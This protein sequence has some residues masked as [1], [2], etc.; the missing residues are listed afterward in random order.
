MPTALHP[1]A[2]FDPIPPDL[3]LHALVE[4]TPH[5]QW[6]TRITAAQI[7]NIGPQEFEKLVFLRVIQQGKPLVIEKWNDRLPKSLF[8]ADWLEKQY[9]KKQ[10]NVRDIVAQTDIPMTTGHYLRS[11]KQL[12]NQWTPATFRDERRQRLYLKDIDCPPEWFDRLQKIIPPN[13]FYMN[14]NVDKKGGSKSGEDLDMFQEGYS[15]APAGDL[16]SSLPEQMRAQN[17]MCYIG[18]EGTYTPAHKEMCASLG[19]NIMVDASGDENGEKP[20]SS[21]WFMTETKDRQVVREYFLSMLGHD[22][23]IEKHFAQINAWKKA[24]FPVYIVE[25]R[26]GDF[27]LVPPLAPHQVWNRGTRTIKVAWNR[28]TVETLE[29]ALH[30]ALPKARLVCRD[31][32]YKNKAIIYYTLEKYAREMKEMEESADIGILGFG[33]DLVRNSTRMKQMAAD[34][35]SLFRLFTEILV[36]EMFATKEKDVEYIEFD[37]CITCSYCRAN[38]FN[39]FLTC[40]HCVRQL[41]NGDEDTYDVCMECYAMGRSCLC[42]SNLSWCEQW[43]WSELVDR[44]E[45]WRA[46]IIKNDG[47]VSLEH[48]PPPLELARRRSGKKSLA[49]ICQEQLR[50]RPWKDLSIIEKPAPPP[51]DETSEVEIGENGRPLKKHT[52]RKRKKGDVYACHVC[53]HKDYC[54][55]L[56]FCSNEGCTNAYCFGVLY[57]AFDQMPQDIL[58]ALRWECPKCQGICNCAAC[59]RAGNSNPYIPKNTTLGHDTR[60]IADDRSVESLVDFRV[61]NL[62]WLKSV[63]EEGRSVASKRI[64]RLQ[65][66]AESEKAREADLAHQV[67][68]LPDRELAET[69]EAAANGTGPQ[70]APN[71]NGVGGTAQGNL[72]EPGMPVADMSMGQGASDYPDPSILNHTVG[73]GYY[74]QDDSPDRILFDP[75]Q[76]PTKEALVVDEEPEM[77]SEYLKKQLRIAKRRTRNEDDDP[78]FAAPRSHWRK[79]PKIDHAEKAD[80]QHDVLDNMDPALF[81]GDQAML[82]APGDPDS[83]AEQGGATADASGQEAG[84]DAEHRPF[85]PN[86]PALRHARPKESYLEDQQEDEFNDVFVPRSQRPPEGITNYDPEVASKDPLDVAAAAIFSAAPAA[87]A[88]E[89]PQPEKK[90]PG[91]KP[92]RPKSIGSQATPKTPAPGSGGPKPRGRP[93]RSAQPSAPVADEDNDSADIDAQLAEQLNAFD[94]DGE[95]IAPASSSTPSIHPLLNQPK[96]RGRPP[97]ASLPETASAAPVSASPSS[98][99]SMADRMKL[100]GKKFKI[101]ARKSINE[102]SGSSGASPSVPL[103]TIEAPESTASPSVTTPAEESP[104]PTEAKPAPRTAIR[105]RGGFRGRGR[106]RGGGRPAGRSVSSKPVSTSESTS[107]EFDPTAAEEEVSSDENSPSPSRDA[108]VSESGS[109]SPEPEPPR[110]VSKVTAPKPATKAIPEP[111]VYRSPSPPPRPAGPTVVR[112]DSVEL[113]S[114]TES[115]SASEES[116]ASVASDSDSDDEDIPA[117]KGQFSGTK[118]ATRGGGVRGRG[119][120]GRGRGRPRLNA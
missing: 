35:K 98:F 111:E 27:I 65:Q 57:R 28:T 88:Q 7:R 118:L 53:G 100:K 17:L 54:Y 107:D 21:I 29:M 23:E 22:I 24:T 61:H 108:S 44:Y 94:D 18:H 92:G 120:G 15:A 99:M 4:R 19:Q 31:E 104:A 47:F 43:R 38:I 78:D 14:E 109:F 30:E 62:T 75:Y 9:N 8:S 97:R 11:M 89:A 26:V 95:F 106:G 69:L 112:L 102:P 55:R 96:R 74:E 46:L 45:E 10:E 3:D 66:A 80:A 105:G 73:R 85:S 2:K 34:F 71:Q 70:D 49:Q 56:A 6:V 60:P 110:T 39:R 91:R 84:G 52:K 68:V 12:T 82:D 87:P 114:G 40:K 119:R 37:S 79:R 1:Q 48:S 16:M 50:R 90:K 51:E 81:S 93:P 83:S 41:V 76:A 72:Q 101:T 13:V 63:G 20:G 115:E 59:R 116:E 117:H 67:P 113:G 33:Q 86:R 77:M 64:Q 5:F 32:Q 58:Q 103:P 42:V 36:D 25:Q